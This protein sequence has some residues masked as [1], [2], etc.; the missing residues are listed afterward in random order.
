ME[1]SSRQLVHVIAASTG[2]RSIERGMPAIYSD[3]EVQT[4]RFNGAALN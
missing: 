2:P 1:R 4:K 3:E